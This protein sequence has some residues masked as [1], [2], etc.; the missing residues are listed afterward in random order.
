MCK[1][2]KYTVN[3][4]TVRIA[5]SPDRKPVVESW[6]NFR[7]PRNWKIPLSIKKPIP[8]GFWGVQ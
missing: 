2:K 7:V 3:I 4:S 5:V 1:E 8:V 6:N